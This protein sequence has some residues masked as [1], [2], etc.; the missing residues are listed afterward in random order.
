[1]P[2]SSARL[3]R[4]GM[5]EGGK[6]QSTW[7]EP[8]AV[9]LKRARSAVLGWVVGC[10]DRRAHLLQQ[11]KDLKAERRSLSMDLANESKELLLRKRQR[12]IPM[13]P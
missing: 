4:V 7:L 13:A 1:M 10:R 11:Q 5:R 2:K 3:M 8:S 12:G 9:R 6:A